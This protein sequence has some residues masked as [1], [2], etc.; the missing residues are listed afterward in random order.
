MLSI[1]TVTQHS[2]NPTRRPTPEED[3]SNEACARSQQRR[4][5]GHRRS[6]ADCPDGPHSG[7]PRRDPSESADATYQLSARADQARCNGL[8]TAINSEA[9]REILGIRE[10]GQGG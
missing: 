4:R 9:F 6:F 3:V 2:T 8:S 10:G 1:R 5:R 7:A